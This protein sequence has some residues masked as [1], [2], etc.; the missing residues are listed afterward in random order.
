[1]ALCLIEAERVNMAISTTPQYHTGCRMSWAPSSLSALCKMWNRSWTLLQEWFWLCCAQ[2]SPSPS[3]PAQP[4]LWCLQP[5]LLPAA[6]LWLVLSWHFPAL[7]LCGAG[8]CLLDVFLCQTML[9]EWALWQHTWRAPWASS[10]QQLGE[11]MGTATGTQQSGENLGLV[12]L[13]PPSTRR[14]KDAQENSSHFLSFLHL[15]WIQTQNPVLRTNRVRTPCASCNFALLSYSA[16]GFVTSGC[17]WRVQS[18]KADLCSVDAPHCLV[19]LGTLSAHCRVQQVDNHLKI[20]R[21]STSI[22]NDM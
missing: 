18:I 20:L 10:L 8:F 2:R 3:A 11:K 1:M 4:F 7:C 16:Q 21:K 22:A 17:L 14:C 6:W 12:D 5:F 9:G 15:C 13:S 19:Q